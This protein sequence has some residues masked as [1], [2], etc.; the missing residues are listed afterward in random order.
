MNVDDLLEKNSTRMNKDYCHS[1][2]NLRECIRSNISL[3]IST[4]KFDGL[5]KS[6]K[7][8]RF[9]NSRLIITVGYKA[10]FGKF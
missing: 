9:E 7:M 2:R 10:A 1:Q 8:A 5:V 4:I 6:R 3:V